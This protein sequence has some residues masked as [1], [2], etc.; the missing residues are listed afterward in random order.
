MG[1]SL[2]CMIV[3]YD[4][5]GADLFYCD[6]EGHRLRGDLFSVGSGSPYAYGVLDN[7]YRYDMEDDEAFELA[8]KAIFAATYR[9]TAS[10]G[11]VRGMNFVS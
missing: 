11:R 2:G 6:N 1:L 5:N 10:G 7:G 4:K 9:D 8:R 3:G